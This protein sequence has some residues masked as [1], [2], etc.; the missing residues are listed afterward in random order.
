MSW[1]TKARYD[2]EFPTDEAFVYIAW[3]MDESRPLYIGKTRHLMRRMAGHERSSPWFPYLRRLEVYGYPSEKKALIAEAEAIATM[4]PEYNIVGAFGNT[5]PLVRYLRRR[6][7]TPP[8]GYG[9]EITTDEI[10]ADQLAIIRRVQNRGR[11]A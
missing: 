2:F 10:S 5:P 8:P 3:G 1:R 11:A 6:R 7:P 9:P 4:D